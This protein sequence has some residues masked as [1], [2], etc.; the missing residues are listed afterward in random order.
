MATRQFSYP[1]DVEEVKGGW[2]VACSYHLH[3][4]EFV[5]DGDGGDIGRLSLGKAGGGRGSGD[6]EFHYPVALATVPGL[7]LVVRELS[8]DGRLQVFATPDAMAMYTNMSGIR[9]AW[10]STCA[11]AVF[12]RRANMLS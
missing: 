1:T 12:N 10:M 2:L 6:G 8:N 7:G 4:V 3:T 9:I 11:R 5:S